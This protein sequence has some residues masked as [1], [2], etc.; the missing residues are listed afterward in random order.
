V[1][2]VPMPVV[3]PG[4]TPADTPALTPEEPPTVPAAPCAAVPPAPAANAQ[5]DDMASAVVNTIVVA[6]C[7]RL[8]DGEREPL[9]PW[10]PRKSAAWPNES[11]KEAHGDP[12]WVA[13]RIMRGSD[14]RGNT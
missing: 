8:A 7:S 3:V 6:N 12:R 5:P 2:P 4:A 10:S 14:R 9:A 11:F 1:V 13:G